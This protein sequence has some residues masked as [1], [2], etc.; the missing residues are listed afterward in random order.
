MTIREMIAA[1]M[2]VEG[3]TD[4]QETVIITLGEQHYEV[5]D[6]LEGGVE[7]YR[8]HICAENPEVSHAG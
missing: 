4:P 7:G 6:V 1:L 8:C 3:R 2:I 5:S